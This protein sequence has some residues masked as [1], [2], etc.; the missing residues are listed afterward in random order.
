[1]A[2]EL[3]YDRV[4]ATTTTTGTGTLTLGSAVTGF[5]AWSVVGNGN[6]AFY[7]IEAVDSNGT[8]TGAW[9]VGTGV[10]TSSGTTLTRSVLA[11]SN[12]G[13]LVNFAAGTKRV[14]LVASAFHIRGPYT[15]HLRDEKSAGTAGGDFTSGS[16]Q[17]RV[18]NTEA[19]DTGSH[20]TLASNQFALLAGTYE[21]TARAPGHACV[22]HQTRLQNVTDAT[23]TL[24]GSPSISRAASLMPTDSWV[25]GRFTITA[26]KTFELQHRCNTTRATDGLG[27]AGNF[28]VTEVYAEV[29]LKKVG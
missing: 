15:I 27:T 25:I 21:I 6:S 3:F 18:L 24:V 17:T 2:N 8:P 10:Y 20:C 16:W 12:S 22:Q 26:T 29:W 9:E 11:S 14:S 4:M 5:Q 7:S 13:S 1:M 23:T 19:Q 28:A